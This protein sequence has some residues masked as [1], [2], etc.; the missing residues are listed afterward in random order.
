MKCPKCGGSSQYGKCSSRRCGYESKERIEMQ[1]AL[2]GRRIAP[3]LMESMKISPPVLLR[4]VKTESGDILSREWR[5]PQC[6]GRGW[7][8]N[9]CESC[10]LCMGKGVCSEF[11]LQ[12][13]FDRLLR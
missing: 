1:M 11:A 8:L 6:K 5:C 12:L 4:E 10:R 3:G 7:E 2:F 13:H 9:A